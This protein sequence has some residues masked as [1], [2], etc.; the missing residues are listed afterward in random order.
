[1]KKEE[2][3]KGK[4]KDNSTFTKTDIVLLRA[5]ICKGDKT[6]DRENYRYFTKIPQVGV[7]LLGNVKWRRM[8]DTEAKAFW[9]YFMVQL[10]KRQILHFP[11]CNW[12]MF[13]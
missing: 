10:Q 8:W 13:H 4:K 6:I 1:M 9:L 5:D 11:Q 7:R 12:I 2:T 3:Q